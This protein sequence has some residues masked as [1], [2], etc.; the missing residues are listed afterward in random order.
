MGIYLNWRRGKK[1]R[2]RRSS[3]RVRASLLRREAQLVRSIKARR[4]K[5]RAQRKAAQRR[6]LTAGQKKWAE[7]RRRVQVARRKKRAKKLA[8]WRRYG[9]RYGRIFGNSSYANKERAKWI[10]NKIRVLMH[11]GYPQKQAIAIAFRMAGV[12]K[13][14]RRKSRR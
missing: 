2:T 9:H 7:R 4:A 14:K 11:E 8:A 10:S 12:P 1:K 6:R 5:K 3:K 13:R